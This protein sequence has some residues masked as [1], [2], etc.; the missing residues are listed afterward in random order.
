MILNEQPKLSAKEDKGSAINWMRFP[1][2]LFGYMFFCVCVCVCVLLDH[3]WLSICM[4]ML[5]FDRSEW[6]LEQG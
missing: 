2:I 1:Y 4:H 6:V 5:V 3:D